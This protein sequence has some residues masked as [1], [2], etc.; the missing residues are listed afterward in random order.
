[1]SDLPDGIAAVVFSDDGA[2]GCVRVAGS[3]VHLTNESPWAVLDR[4]N[5]GFAAEVATLFKSGAAH[6]RGRVVRYEKRLYECFGADDAFRKPL[7]SF[8]RLLHPDCRWAAGNDIAVAVSDGCIV[9]IIA[10]V[11]HARVIAAGGAS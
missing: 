4:Y 8:V 9:A 11:A 3:L 1:M 6:K 7:T 10:G 5:E 2:N